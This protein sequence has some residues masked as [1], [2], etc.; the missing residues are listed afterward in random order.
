MR[1][2]SKFKISGERNKECGISV[3]NGKKERILIQ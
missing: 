1:G 2:D 3:K